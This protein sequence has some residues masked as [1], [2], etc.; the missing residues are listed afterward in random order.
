LLIFSSKPCNFSPSFDLIKNNLMNRQVYTRLALFFIFSMKSLGLLAQIS[1]GGIPLSIS[2]KI[3]TSI[4]VFETVQPN[5][6]NI[7]EQD[8]KGLASFRFAIPIAINLDTKNSGVWTSL[9]TGGRVWQLK[10]RSKNALGLAT[11]FENFELPEGSK[12]FMYS[13]DYKQVFGAYDASNNPK[14]RRLLVG[15]TKGEETIIEY[16]ETK[17]PAKAVDFKITQVFHAY[18]QDLL[19]PLDFGES[20][21]CEIN[22]N[23]PEGA[24]W[25]TQKK[26]VVRV[27]IVVQEG[28]GWCTGSL[29]N[30]TRQD[31]TPYILSAYH[32]SD[33]Y[34]PDYG[35]WTFYF[36]YE[37]S[38]CSNPTS[39]PTLQSLQGCVVRA[40]RQQS[41][42]LLLET[43]QRVPASFNAHFNG[44]N[45]DSSNLTTSATM[46]HHPQGDI[47]KITIDNGAPAVSNI[48]NQWISDVAP[49]T[50]PPRSHLRLTPELGFSEGGSSGAPFFDANGLIIAQNHGG[51]MDSAN[52]RILN[53]LGGWLAKSW[54]G[55]GTP[56]TRLKDWL[57]PL[58][59]SPLTLGG[60]NTPATTMVATISGKVS[61]WTG[62][63]LP[64]VTVY[65]GSDSTITDASGNFS[66]PN[67][68]VNQEI[69]VRLS[70]NDSYDN[71][72]NGADVLLMR[73]HILGINEFS[74]KFRLF[75]GDIDNNNDLN[76]GDYLLVR[77]LILGINTSFST[78]TP[79][80]FVTTRTSN[81]TNFPFGITEPSPLL[82]TFTGNVA[83]FDFY[84]YKKGD[85]DGSAELRN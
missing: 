4:P 68:P 16:I 62:V 70:K 74:S 42:F 35:L 61:F 54:D 39:E 55:N 15:M 11:T 79:W 34:T 56:Q 41:D 37:S 84:G 71:G 60:I 43:T 58:S 76:A 78:T 1:N 25:Q 45:R 2:A 21:A 20:R 7:R 9:P 73:R 10:I 53:L 23:C 49:T 5:W 13:P 29:I 83:N 38:N 51:S 8:K 59:T 52:C 48:S 6:A 85:V 26:G 17:K 50:T 28:L 64:S 14:N 3:T 67:V 81:D 40:G 33:G 75:S 57:D 31:G 72:L 46:I 63:A 24:N 80:R 47:K 44:W 30:N 69:E 19:S 32:C 65:I 22:V 66:M 36:N 82:V 12:L 18:N 77:R 27:R